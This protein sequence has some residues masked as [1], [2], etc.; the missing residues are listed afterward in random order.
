MSFIK[1]AKSETDLIN[2]NTP[3][4]CFIGRSN[5]G[6]SSVINAI[7]NQN[8]AKT[9]NTPG[10]TRLINYF[11]YKNFRIVDLPGYGYA[12]VSKDQL[13]DLQKT[14]ENYMLNAPN[15]KCVFQVCDANVITRLDAEMADFFSEH[16]L[17][18]IVVLNKI[19]KKSWGHY[20][21]NITNIAN[22]L[23]VDQTDLIFVSVR[24]KIN[25]DKIKN[26]IFD[27]CTNV[28]NQKDCQSE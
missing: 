23:N 27:V 6:K 19:D 4:V 24:K 10:R 20:K 26:K 5:V 9:S 15:L 3:E 8:I 11:K 12:K 25:I 21:N 14:I 7:F 18:H 28:S 17:K 2:D 22:Y 1:S 16:F 13:V